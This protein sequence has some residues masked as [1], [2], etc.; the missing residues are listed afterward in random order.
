MKNKRAKGNIGE[1]IACKYLI[2]NNYKILEKNFY[3]KGGE[4]DIISFDRNAKEIVFV[5]VKTR[6]NDFYGMPR[7]SVDKKKIYRI[8]K[9]IQVY[10]R[11]KIVE[12]SSVRA[13]LIEIY[14]FKSKFYIN[15]IKQII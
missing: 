7:D 8:T 3:F 2:K 5:E 15:H 4:I 11:Q 12:K 9:G 10:L 14:Y 6:L 13:D 1:Q